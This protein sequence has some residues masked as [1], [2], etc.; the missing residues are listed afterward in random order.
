MTFHRPAPRPVKQMDD[1]TPKPREVVLRRD[2][3]PTMVVPLPKSAPWRCEAY[4]RAVAS[5]PCA[6]C[7]MEGRSQAAHSDEGK[8]LG[9]KASDATAVPLC[10]DVPGR[11]GCHSLL[12]ASGVFTQSQRRTLEKRYIDETQAALK[13]AGLWK[14]EWEQAA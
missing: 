3:P 11:R 7:R 6:H 8:G 1:Y 2:Q 14:P 9:I 13:A 12:G 10:A 5:L 4:R